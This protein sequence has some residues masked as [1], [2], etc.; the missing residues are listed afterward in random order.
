MA[1]QQNGQRGGYAGRG[2]NSN[3]RGGSN[4]G[5]GYNR[6]GQNR[7]G[8]NGGSDRYLR[9]SSFVKN[10]IL[11]AENGRKEPAPME[12][13]VTEEIAFTLTAQK[14]D[15]FIKKIQDA[16]NDPQGDGG[17]RVTMYAQA[18]VNK[19]TGEEFDGLQLMV[20][21]KFPPRNQQQQRGGSF[22]RGGNNGRR[23]YGNSD[24]GQQGNGNANGGTQQSGAAD[25]GNQTRDSQQGGRTQDAQQ[26]A[27]HSS[28][29]QGG[30]NNYDEPGW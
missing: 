18:K 5:G 16:Q 29:A 22:N 11:E 14:A 9:S 10:I 8:N 7:G 28:G 4:G 30:G 26:N 19:D 25:R 21:G 3:N 23:D 17:I 12:P 1:Y 20:V 6:G 2:G 24:G 27:S 15:E 13:G